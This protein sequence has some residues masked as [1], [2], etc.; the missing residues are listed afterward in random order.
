MCKTMQRVRDSP[1]DCLTGSPAAP[2]NPL[3]PNC[4]GI[5]CR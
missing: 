1:L 3:S 2:S 4:P 5:P